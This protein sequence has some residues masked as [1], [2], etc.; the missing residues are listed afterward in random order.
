[1]SKPV[2]AQTSFDEPV[3]VVSSLLPP[4]LED[5]SLST[6]VVPPGPLPVATE[7]PLDV[8]GGSIV[9]AESPDGPVPPPVPAAEYSGLRLAHPHSMHAKATLRLQRTLAS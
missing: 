3:L 2:G 9:A 4:S 5:P 8:A 1:M 7:V 6:L